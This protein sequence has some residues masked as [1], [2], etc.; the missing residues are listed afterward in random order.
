MQDY[1]RAVIV[2]GNQ[3]FGKGT[4]Q[5]FIPLNQYARSDKDLGFLKMTIQKFYR[6]DGGST[7]L[8]GVKPDV[9]VP[10]QYS[11]LDIGERDEKSPMQWDKIESTKY[12]PWDGYSNYDMAIQN[13]RT[14]VFDNP[15]FQLIDS[16]AKWLKKGQED[17]TIYLNFN[18]FKKDIESHNT[19]IAKFDAL[20]AY[21]NHLKFNSPKYEVALVVA[22]SVLA[23]KREVWHTNLTKDVYV[24]EGL[25]ILE[26]LALKSHAEL[27][28]N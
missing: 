3:T 26:E 20:N 24:D 18:E 11:Y 2:G 17:K 14:R 16:N 27:V 6:I 1:K 13:S 9:I 4:V 25:N 10:S 12:S 28:K 5:N 23:K 15:Q 7:Q 19:E 22:D 8:R 21:S